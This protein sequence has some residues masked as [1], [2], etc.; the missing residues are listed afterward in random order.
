M[1]LDEVYKE[2]TSYR[3]KQER[4]VKYKTIDYFDTYENKFI[5]QEIKDNEKKIK[6]GYTILLQESF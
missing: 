4:K 2:E 5:D 3:R 1:N 6:K